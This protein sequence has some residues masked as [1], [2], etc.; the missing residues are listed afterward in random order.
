MRHL[1]CLLIFLTAAAPAVAQSVNKVAIGGAIGTRF[2][3][4][5]TV[6]G[7]HFGVRQLSVWHD[8]SRKVG[9]NV[10]AGY[11]I[12]ETESHDQHDVGRGTPAGPRRHAHAEDGRRLL[13]MLIL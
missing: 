3:P 8:L 13:G 7:D 11:M 2:A 6:G 4:G 1:A 10:T 9:V 12:A 5:P